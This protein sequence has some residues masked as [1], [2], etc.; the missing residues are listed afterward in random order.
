MILDT[1]NN[2]HFTIIYNRAYDDIV[3]NNAKV[4]VR[5]STLSARE[6]HF[7]LSDTL[8]IYFTTAYGSYNRNTFYK[9]NL[10]ARYILFYFNLFLLRLK[11]VLF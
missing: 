5:Q 2:T 11:I 4:T 9:V 1:Y 8:N 3:E 7:P 6:V 10:S